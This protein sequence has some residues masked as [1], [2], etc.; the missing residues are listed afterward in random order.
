MLSTSGR[1]QNWSDV[2]EFVFAGNATFTLVSLKTGARFTYKVRV[3]KEDLARLE[4]D[5][6][7]SAVVG[8]PPTFFTEADV[9]YFVN[10]LRGP[11]N[12]ADFVYMGV[13]RKPGRFFWTA[14]SGKVGRQA[15]AYKALL[16]MLDAMTCE[17]DVLS[18]QLEIWHEGRCG[19]CGRKLTVPESIA[20]GIGP[21]CAGRLEVAA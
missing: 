3:K 6:K 10:L 7:L 13:V 17:R 5:R 2:R 11:D 18:K 16:W 9:T 4:D 21:E 19:R 15:P 8:E 14:A 12:T 1:L 20:A